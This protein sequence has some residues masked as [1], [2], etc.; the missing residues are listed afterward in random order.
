[1]VERGRGAILTVA[2]TA[3]YTPLPNMAGYGAAKAWARSFSGALHE[4]LRSHGIAVTALCPGPVNTEFF[5]VAGPTPIENIIPRQ[6]WVDPDHVARTAL[7]ALER[8]RAEVVPGRPMAALVTGARLV[9]Q[10]LRM[11]FA[12]RFFR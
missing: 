11:P 1:M 12:G 9:P 8:N 4:E 6:F 2:S 7:A 5:D 10:E 3:G